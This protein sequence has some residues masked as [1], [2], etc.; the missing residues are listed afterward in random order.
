MGTGHAVASPLGR[1]PLAVVPFD[2]QVDEAGAGVTA[3]ELDPLLGLQP[4]LHLH[5]SMTLDRHVGP[6]G[7]HV[8]MAAYCLHGQGQVGPTLA[9]SGERNALEGLTEAAS[10]QAAGLASDDGG[11][12]VGVHMPPLRDGRG[13]EPY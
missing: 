5:A 2:L 4:H 11:G 1:R 7:I 6:D 12:G 3:L 10:P 9:G 8:G 13:V